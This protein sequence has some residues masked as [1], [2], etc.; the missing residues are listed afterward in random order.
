MQFYVNGK[1][2]RYNPYHMKKDKKLPEGKEVEAYVVG[3]QVVKFYKPYCN[4]ARLSKEDIEILKH[5]P[6]KR[7]LLPNSSML[8]KKRKIRGYKMD[9]I[10]DL[11]EDTF[12]DLA[13]D[14][15]K[16]E[17][18]Y[19]K[20]DVEILSDSGVILVDLHKFNTVYH[21]GIYLIDPGSYTFI[22]RESLEEKDRIQC[23]GMNIDRINEYLISTLSRFSLV[24]HT[25]IERSFYD[26][27][28]ENM[29]DY[30][31]EREEDT[32]RGYVDSMGK[33]R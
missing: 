18:Q 29:M 13:K 17:M 23:Y 8:D 31:F 1:K 11:G 20:E 4:K 24:K 22:K 32:L 30:L 14:R 6:T 21:N 25:N 5:I 2:E 9:Y 10:E 15:R 33:K 3:D 19:L 12:L 7:I 28:S 16:E 27:G 26:S